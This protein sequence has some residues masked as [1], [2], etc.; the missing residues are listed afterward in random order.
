MDPTAADAIA[1]TREWLEKAVIGLNL[2]PF[3]KPV[4]LKN[5]IRFQASAARTE[6][7]LLHD[8]RH[9]LTLLADVSPEEIDTT[10]LIHPQVMS[11]FLDYNAFLDAAE[12]LLVELDLEG[13]IQIASFHP[14]YYFADTDPEDVSNCTN[15]SPF[16]TL[17][18]IREASLE[19]AI[20]AHPDTSEI[21][22]AN[23]ETM[24]RLGHEG[25]KRLFLPASGQ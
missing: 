4:L 22:R 6:E 8:L 21:Y 24:R 2:C 14:D 20:E 19:R 15:R 5:Q 17:H 10:L 12:A 18:L 25:W 3:A 23:I 1:R 13:V 16:P 7:D 11:D 9:E